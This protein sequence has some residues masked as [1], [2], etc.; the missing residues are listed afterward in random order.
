MIPR[1]QASS[2]SPQSEA[3]LPP[4]AFSRLQAG[5]QRPVGVPPLGGMNFRG[6]KGEDGG[7]LKNPE[8]LPTEF[9]TRGPGGL[10]FYQGGL[11]TEVTSAGGSKTP[12]SAAFALRPWHL[13]VMLLQKGKGTS[14]RGAKGA[15]EMQRLRQIGQAGGLPHIVGSH[16]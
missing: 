9:A 5:L 3:L 2:V 10:L 4:K 8:G 16:L 1:T 6:A 11:A 7:V 12:S 13:C 15:E 14:R